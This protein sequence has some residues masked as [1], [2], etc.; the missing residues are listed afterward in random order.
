MSDFTNKYKKCIACNRK[1]FYDEDFYYGASYYS[2][3]LCCNIDISSPIYNRDNKINSLN[4]IISFEFCYNNMIFSIENCGD[5]RLNTV[6]YFES[7]EEFFLRRSRD[8]NFRIQIAS[9]LEE[10]SKLLSSIEERNNK[11]KEIL[12]F[13]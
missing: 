1:L 8:D 7:T 11:I 10:A 6:S 4:L 3:A 5:F 13:S 9:S 12:I 2:T